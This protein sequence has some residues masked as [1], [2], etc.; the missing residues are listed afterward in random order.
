MIFEEL[1]KMILPTLDYTNE[2]SNRKPGSGRDSSYKR[3][4]ELPGVVEDPGIGILFTA[5]GF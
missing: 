2:A 1:Q 3:G 4:Y 5:I